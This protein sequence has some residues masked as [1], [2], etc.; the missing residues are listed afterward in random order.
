MIG[1]GKWG[2][3]K[4]WRLAG[5]RLLKGDIGISQDESR[6]RCSHDPSI[7]IRASDVTRPST[8]QITC[9]IAVFTNKYLRVPREH[10]GPCPCP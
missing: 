10:V 8:R 7:H 6:C 9:R 4:R 3:S 1:E 5:S 2:V